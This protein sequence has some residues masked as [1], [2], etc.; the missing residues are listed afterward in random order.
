MPGL[1][2][3][4]D[5]VRVDGRRGPHVPC[6]GG[7]VFR[8]ARQ[9]D[10]ER[11]NPLLAFDSSLTITAQIVGQVLR[12]PATQDDLGAG[13][14]GPAT[15]AVTNGDATISGPF[16]F[17]TSLG[18]SP[19]ASRASLRG[20]WS[21]RRP[22]SVTGSERSTLLNP[23]S[24]RPEILVHP[25]VP[26]AKVNG[27]IRFAGAALVLCLI[28]TLAATFAWDSMP[29]RRARRTGLLVNGGPGGPPEFGARVR[30]PTGVDIEHEALPLP[31]FTQFEPVVES[32]DDRPQP[33][34]PTSEPA[35]VAPA[36]QADDAGSGR[37]PTRRPRPRLNNGRSPAPPGP[38]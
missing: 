16:L 23:P 21:G 13:A 18:N 36:G 9:E 32:A 27:K 6:V 38:V 35:S 20:F 3:D 34:T 2:H 14:G 4:S 33:L 10:V 29:S 11:I 26:E 24:S 37:T 17:V 1:R 7:E 28:G 8:E 19:E 5:P 31:G 15:Y 12:D 22:N 25:T 30:R